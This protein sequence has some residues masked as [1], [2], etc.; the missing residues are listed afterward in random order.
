[1]VRKTSR[2]N[3]EG[4]APW[5]RVVF[6]RPGVLLAMHGFKPVAHVWFWMVGPLFYFIQLIKSRND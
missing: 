2:V 6:V 4:R 3:P 1:M 5:D